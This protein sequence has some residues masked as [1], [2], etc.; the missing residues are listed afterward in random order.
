[1][2]QYVSFTL[3]MSCSD[4][5][6]K[7]FLTI[8]FGFVFPASLMRLSPRG[9]DYSKLYSCDFIYRK[10]LNAYKLMIVPRYSSIK[11]VAIILNLIITIV[12]LIFC[13]SPIQ[14]HIRYI[15]NNKTITNQFLT[16][17]IL[18]KASQ[19]NNELVGAMQ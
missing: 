3:T 11:Y 9:R 15:F 19:Y 4:I 12:I 14:N 18:L 10:A 5:N 2:V 7:I 1:M 8:V 17:R 13:S 6:P 16:N